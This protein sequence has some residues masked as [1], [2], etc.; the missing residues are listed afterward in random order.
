MF[1]NLK[2]TLT[3]VKSVIPEKPQHFDDILAAAAVKKYLEDEQNV[4]IEGKEYS[5]IINF[6]PLDKHNENDEDWVWKSS[7]I[8][9]KNKGLYMKGVTQAHDIYKFAEMRN[10]GVLKYNR[11]GLDTASGSLK[12]TISLLPSAAYSVGVAYCVGDKNKVEDLLSHLKHIGR[13]HKRGGGEIIN[14]EV[15][16]EENN[17]NWKDR[18]LPLSMTTLINDNHFLAN[19]IG[20]NP[21]YWLNKKTMGWAIPSNI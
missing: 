8:R 16:E 15:K 5:D 1:K 18:F 9:W 11:A 10:S 20:I 6:L 21:P 7:V 3:I 4:K 19:N 13:L 2:I 14:Y 17:D 12:S